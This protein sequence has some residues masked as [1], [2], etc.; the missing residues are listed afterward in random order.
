MALGGSG[1]HLGYYSEKVQ[2]GT[3]HRLGGGG[4]RGVSCMDIF[5]F[6]VDLR[7]SAKDQVALKHMEGTPCF[8]ANPDQTTKLG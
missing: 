4:A 3:Q 2:H 8:Q 5:G 6:H 7:G 1:N